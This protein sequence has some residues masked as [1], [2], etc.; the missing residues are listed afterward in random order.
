MKV[1]EKIKTHSLYSA[2]VSPKKRNIYEIMWKNCGRDR[3]ATDEN[4]MWRRKCSL[5]VG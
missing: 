3:Q 1:V 4:M 2:N 5:R